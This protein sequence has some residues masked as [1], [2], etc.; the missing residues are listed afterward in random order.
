MSKRSANDAPFLGYLPPPP[1]SFDPLDRPP[2]RPGVAAAIVAS[3][4]EDSDDGA[5]FEDEIAGPVH[6][7]NEEGTP[8]KASGSLEL[9]EP[10]TDTPPETLKPIASAQT[11][12]APHVTPAENEAAADPRELARRVAEQA[13]KKALGDGAKKAKAPVEPIV[14]APEP[15]VKHEP[16]PRVEAPQKTEAK[17]APAKRSLSDRAARPLSTADALREAA[18]REAAEAKARRRADRAAARA[19]L[20]ADAET[21]EVEAPPPEP[22]KRR[23]SEAAAPAPA[24]VA[25]SPLPVAETLAR[26]LP[27]A[28]LIREV[29]VSNVMIFRALWTAHRARAVATQDLALLAT[30]AVLLDAVDRV[31]AGYLMAAHARTAGRDVAVWFDVERGVLLGIAEPPEVYLAGL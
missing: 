14:V 23:V 11:P 15:P 22:R 13:R 7:K 18:V 2:E 9:P 3:D 26:I 20:S 19:M 12:I 25:A 30:S 5:P 21:E 16:A 6:I 1:G 4:L 17:A 24:P 28:E 29:P 10:E 27:K 8:V 31:P